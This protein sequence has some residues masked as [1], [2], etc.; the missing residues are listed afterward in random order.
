MCNVL[1]EKR[2]PVRRMVLLVE[3]GVR[4]E[5]THPVRGIA[6]FEAAPFIHS[7]NLPLWSLM[8]FIQLLSYEKTQ[9]CQVN[10]V[11]ES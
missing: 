11:M 1:E 3:E 5:L 9:E 4:F 10:I 7:G 2:K 6:A 8:T